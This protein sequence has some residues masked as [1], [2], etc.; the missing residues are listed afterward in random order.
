MSG[1]RGHVSPTVA[2]ERTR[3]S[4]WERVVALLPAACAVHCVLT[5]FVA[6]AVPLIAFGPAGEWLA[7]AV[8]GFLAILAVASTSRVHGIR[9]VWGPVVVGLLV[10][11]LSAAD[12]LQLGSGSEWTAGMGGL[13]VAAGVVWSSR[14]RHRNVCA[15]SGCVV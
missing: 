5:P 4:S 10:W 6:A 12:F 14:L 15:G 3:G 8:S 13:L 7:F 11:G 1:M 2:P 9:L